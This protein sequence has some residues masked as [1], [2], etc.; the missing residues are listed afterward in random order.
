MARH[1]RNDPVA[2]PSHRAHTRLASRA[3]CVLHASGQTKWGHV[4]AAL[5]QASV[6]PVWAP[7]VWVMDG[8]ANETLHGWVGFPAE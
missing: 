2:H 7:A 6:L 4:A 1:D 5:S 8:Q 3:T